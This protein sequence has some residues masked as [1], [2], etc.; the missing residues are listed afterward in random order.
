MECS[1]CS[2]SN[3]SQARFCG[4]CGR[5][6]PKACPA[7]GS[8][9]AAEARFCQQCGTSLGEAPATARPATPA[10]TAAPAG[11]K[12]LVTVLALEL[13][14]GP[15]LTTRLGA[16][17]LHRVRN[18]LLEFVLQEVGRY[19]G[20]VLETAG[21]GGVL[22]L[23]GAPVAHED[24]ARRAV[25]AAVGLRRR[26][27][28]NLARLEAPPGIELT[29]RQGL[30]TGFV[31]VGGLG[32]SV[33]GT[34]PDTA[35]TLRSR[36]ADEEILATSTT[37]RRLGAWVHT[38]VLPDGHLRIGERVGG[39]EEAVFE[40]G[41]LS[42]FVGRDQELALLR[43]ALEEADE[44]RG[45]VVG[46]AGDAGA[47]KSRL[48]YELRG[49]LDA[50]GALRLSGHCLPY[51][52]SLPYHP[53]VIL[54][55]QALRL[56]GEDSAEAPPERLQ[57]GLSRLGLADLPGRRELGLLL[58]ERGDEET[59][60]AT[61]PESPALKERIFDAVK[62]FITALGEE[63]L[64][65]IEIEDLHW[66][67][68]TSAELLS[69]LVDR[70]GAARKLLLTTYRS[71]YRPAFLDRSFATQ[72]ALRPLSMTAGRQVVDALLAGVAQ[73]AEP[74]KLARK[75]LARADGNPL[76]LEELA[77]AVREQN[78][79]K[80]EIPDTVHGLLAARVDRL[81]GDHRRL[82]RA[83]AVLGREPSRQ[84]LEAIW[85][86]P[87]LDPLLADLKAWELLYERPAG[88]RPGYVF[89]HAL[90]QEVTYQALLEETRQ[91]VHRRAGEA[92]E[93]LYGDHG[94]EVYDLLAY[95][96]SR[97]GT[98]SEAVRYL[99]LLAS[100]A[101]RR[102]AHAE[103]ARALGEAI[104]IAAGLP[105]DEREARTVELVIR[106]AAAFLPLARLE[107]TLE[108]LQR[109]EEMVERV[110]DPRLT[111][112]YRFW[113][114]HTHSYL[115]NQQE[116]QAHALAA[117]EAGRE[118]G[119]EVTQGM[120]LYVLGRDHF[121][122]GNFREGL[123]ASR[124]AVILLER[125]AEPWWQGQAHWVAGFHLFALGDVDG[126]F[127]SMARCRTI[128]EALGDYRLDPSWSEGYFH[129]AIGQLDRGIELCQQ[130]VEVAKDPLNRAAARGFLG[131]ALLRAKRAEEAREALE[132]AVG[133]MDA[134]G[135]R[136]LLGW[137]MIYLGETLAAL[138]RVDE[139]QAV[140][141]EALTVCRQAGFKYGEGLALRLT[142]RTFQAAHR[143]DDAQRVLDQALST[144]TDMGATFETAKVYFERAR[145]EKGR[146]K[147]AEA[148]RERE[149]GEEMLELVR[150]AGLEKKF[151]LE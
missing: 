8:E 54:L 124:E 102:S 91:A 59:A 11:E 150:A 21:G 139:G 112:R 42:P 62:G 75:I 79:S 134:T 149:A 97:A 136:P 88:E 25:L 1:H 144:F 122:S 85:D 142:G 135:M 140:V 23:F 81:P 147:V 141:D 70:V 56:D 143:D 151:D 89:K 33:T 113:L 76:F 44:E 15:E 103:A 108:L 74:R 18:R 34:V 106:R 69:M 98:P 31:I 5:P 117:L 55:R 46:I 6:L 104:D 137:F 86:G 115:G 14:G 110:D 95:H 129:S 127:E 131:Y 63:R 118:A 121:W 101:I 73:D 93:R 47:G 109:H 22:A 9:V 66:I 45:Q 36:A 78:G 26:V 24:H 4:G 111:G 82:L 120:A 99:G 146:G 128:G 65:V 12:K 67:D 96:Y 80:V 32:S 35:V 16:E 87:P 148:E 132:T 145:F 114:A 41:A 107:A 39:A 83:A 105:E 133:T 77:R 60:R 30:D 43:S 20:T 50:R 72:I 40:E 92:L 51:G 3:P 19:E 27:R 126:A 7:C 17:A 64:L 58:L 138:G 125:T 68:E 100:Q 116:A 10:P 29:L 90:T 28:Q 94:D 48:L 53:F 2:F 61:A 123:E 119:D 37:M 38:E 71:G 13:G 84:L 130:G 57:E 49:D 52:A